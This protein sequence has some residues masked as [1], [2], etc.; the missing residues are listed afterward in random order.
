[1][2][3]KSKIAFTNY[4]GGKD[5]HFAIIK[6]IEL[7][8]NLKLLF[9][10][11]AG[12]L[13]HEIFNEFP[14]S[15]IIKK[16][17]NLM[18]IRCYEYKYNKMEIPFL[19]AIRKSVKI[20]GH[21]EKT[22]FISSMDYDLTKQDRKIT[23]NIISGIRKMGIKY[24]SVVK[25]NDMFDIIEKTLS[26]GIRYIITAVEKNVSYNWLG[27]VIDEGFIRYLKD[28]KRKGNTITANDFQT[29]VTESPIMKKRLLI[30][31]SEIVDGFQRTTSI[32]L[33][34]KKYRFV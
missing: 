10:F 32:L 13:H 7:G 31:S 4:S 6:A 30:K 25:G 15:D 5:S 28:E 21:E 26:K 2:T 19:D 22:I 14:K 16:Q 12:K 33:K 17:A 27:K 11:N 1:M 23:N 18:G 29:L 8:Y 34:I 9:T 24:I 20:I 3:E